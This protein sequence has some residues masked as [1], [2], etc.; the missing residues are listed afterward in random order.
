MTPT[1]PDPQA[2]ARE[3][4]ARSGVT[5]LHEDNHVL[6]ISKPAGL[7]SQA[8]P[9]DATAL[10]EILAAYR[11]ER[12]GKEGRAYVGL[13]HRL[14][15]N[16][17]GAMVVA[18]T[19]KAAGRL[20]R[21]FRA[22]A[23]GLRKVYLAWVAGRPVGTAGEI[24]SRLGRAGGVTREEEGEGG[25]E[26][27]LAW[28][29]EGT[30]RGSSRLRIELSTGLP[31]QIRAQLAAAGHPLV[32]DRKYGGPDGPRPALHALRLVVPHPVLET[33]VDLVAAVPSDLLEL[34]RALRIAP[35]VDAW[36]GSRRR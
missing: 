7:L 8:G 5:I 6:G 14:D 9:K 31:H 19:S 32:G 27:R 3:R 1:G 20:A 13:V 35:A 26:G 23:A 25:R 22:R 11:R 28:T 36:S 16:V 2:E 17:S 15:R 24:V 30:G 10:P 21:A 29:L 4:L 18:K 33:P 12:E 34:D